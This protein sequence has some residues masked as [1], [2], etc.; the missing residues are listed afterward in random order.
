MHDPSRP[1][2]SEAPDPEGDGGGG[3]SPATGIDRADWYQK[4]SAA[5]IG[6]EIAVAICLGTFG[7]RW[8]EENWTHW[9]PWTTV[10]GFFAGVGAAGLAIWRVVQEH[11]AG[12]EARAAA[13]EAQQN[14]QTQGPSIDEL[15]ANPTD[16]PRLPSRAED[17]QP[18]GNATSPVSVRASTLD[19]RDLPSSRR[20]DT[21][22]GSLD[23]EET[24]P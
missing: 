16:A 1:P 24:L 4:T 9:A 21:L 6:I 10:I 2:S 20:E 15:G 3:P 18:H 7:G 23:D 14:A 17:R 11:Q 12:V 22:Q 8:I 13:R 19:G 5:S